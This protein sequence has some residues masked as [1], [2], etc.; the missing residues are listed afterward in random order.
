MLFATILSESCPQWYKLNFTC[1]ISSKSQGIHSKKN[2]CL[3]I[4]NNFPPQSTKFIGI[5]Q[6]WFLRTYC[7]VTTTRVWQKAGPSSAVQQ[8]WLSP[9]LCSTHQSR[10]RVW[11]T[12]GHLEST[13]TACY[14][15]ASRGHWAVSPKSEGGWT[16]KGRTG[17]TSLPKPASFW[18][19]S[20]AGF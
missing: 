15:P 13:P 11:R 16:Q 17:P 5:V 20:A 9:S 7:E 2:S 1:C 4:L 3:V 18:E 8:P 12:S 19:S 6:H 10:L 14:P